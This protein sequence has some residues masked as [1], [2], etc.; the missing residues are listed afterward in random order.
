MKRL[1]TVWLC[2][3]VFVALGATYQE[4]AVAAV[5]MGEAGTEGARGMTAVA[6]V[7]HQRAIQKDWT[8]L[9]VVSAHRGYIHAFSCLNGTTLNRLIQ[10]FSRDREYQKALRIARIL[11]QAPA[12]L[13][14]LVNAANHY[15][16]ATEHPYWARGKR[17]VA[18]VGRL[19]FYKLKH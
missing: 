15:T 4:R 14:R 12:R 7:I 19:A 6:D 16:N 9:H 8:P 5:L 17:P 2:S 3:V 1:L 13:P 18:F 10:K 11:C